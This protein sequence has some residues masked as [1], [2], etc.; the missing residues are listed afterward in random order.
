MPTS[1][2]L[3]PSRGGLRPLRLLAPRS[4]G[5]ELVHRITHPNLTPL[6]LFVQLIQ[7]LIGEGW[8]G[9]DHAAV[10]LA[11]D[12]ALLYQQLLFLCIQVLDLLVD[13]LVGHVVKL[14]AAHYFPP[15]RSTILSFIQASTELMSVY[16]I[17][18]IT[19]A[20]G[21]PSS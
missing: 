20:A 2:H 1:R 15:C 8:D 11:R 18:L 7:L 16:S 13:L 19:L 6:P 4:L 21:K 17:S 10:T 9:L 3:L 14:A 12:L 5:A